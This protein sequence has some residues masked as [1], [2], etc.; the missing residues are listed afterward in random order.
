MLILLEREESNRSV[1]A[2]LFESDPAFAADNKG[3]TLAK[4]AV[5]NVAELASDYRPVRQLTVHDKVV[6]TDDPEGR[7]SRGL[8]WDVV[9]NCGLS[10]DGDSHDGDRLS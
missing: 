9:K 10:A 6:V 1:N 2:A 7:F 3:G 4:R 8:V 5:C